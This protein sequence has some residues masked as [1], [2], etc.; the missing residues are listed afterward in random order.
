MLKPE[1]VAESKEIILSELA[2]G[3]S[4]VKII[5]EHKLPSYKTIMEWLRKESN[6]FDPVFLQNYT[7]ARENQ[8]DFYFNSIVDIADEEPDVAKAKVRI[9]ARKWVAGKMRPKVYGERLITE[10]ENK[11]INIDLSDDEIDRK[12]EELKKKL[13]E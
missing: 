7:R 10:N 13:S 12:L 4:L 9:D 11:N 1:Y 8:A 3:K 5:E 6:L 2:V